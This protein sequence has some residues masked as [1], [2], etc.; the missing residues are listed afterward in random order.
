MAV[1]DATFLIDLDKEVP[2]AGAQLD[3]LEEDAEP[4]RVPA[5]V[6]VE[7]LHTFP[8][9]RRREA[10]RLLE[11]LVLFEP[12]SRSL[13]DA[14]ARLRHELRNAGARLGW[15]DLQVAT[16]ALHHDEPVVS[17]DRGLEAVPGLV[18]QT[19]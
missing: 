5:A 3:R 7:Y 19:Y 11:G 1:L 9:A 14:A 12:F 8:P 15:H 16:T 18:L 13:A 17:R 2:A 10:R 4:L 6:W